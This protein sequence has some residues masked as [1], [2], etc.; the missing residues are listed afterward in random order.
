MPAKAQPIKLK[1]AVVK[2]IFT[3]GNFSQKSK[4]IQLPKIESREGHNAIGKCL[5]LSL[6]R[7][8]TENS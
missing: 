7:V 4:K 2:I 6:D 5:G 8:I 3:K 1:I